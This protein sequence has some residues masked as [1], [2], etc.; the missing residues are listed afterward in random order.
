MSGH[1]SSILLLLIYK[2]DHTLYHHVTTR[3]GSY[4]PTFLF[5]IFSF[6]P[7]SFLFFFFLYIFSFFLTRQPPLTF[8]STTHYIT[9]LNLIPCFPIYL[10][11]MFSFQDFLPKL[12]L[13][14]LS[15][16]HLPISLQI[17]RKHNTIKRNKHT[18]QIKQHKKKQK[19][20]VSPFGGRGKKGPA[21]NNI[22]MYNS[23]SLRNDHIFNRRR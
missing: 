17:K 18:R 12:I 22:N 3:S 8:L 14:Y 15:S 4:P 9:I 20:S 7:S 21:G 16:L 6:L 1:I 2:A 19:K 10:L 11:Y 5:F 23:C 13:S